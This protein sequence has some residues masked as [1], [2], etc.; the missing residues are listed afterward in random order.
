MSTL[1]SASAAEST[2]APAD[3]PALLAR[4]GRVS[5]PRLTW[6]GAAGER[7]E[8]SGRVLVNWVAKTAHLLLDELDAAPGDFVLV[9]LGCSW[10]APAIWLAAWHLGCQVDHRAAQP[11]PAATASAPAIAVIR[12]G[13]APPTGTR[14][15]LVVATDVLARRADT[16]P[17]AAVDYAAEVTGQDDA[18]PPPAASGA[19]PWRGQAT[20]AGRVLFGP[21]ATTGELL[22][23]WAAGGSVVWHD[24]LAEQELRRVIETERATP[25]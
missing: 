14:R 25:A 9:A 10:R 18:L 8:L 6:Y 13:D 19:R 5:E 21:G 22:A 20:P 12:D 17:P 1:S 4:L 3:V 24:G 11:G 16:L 15:V 23:V 7:V 2:S